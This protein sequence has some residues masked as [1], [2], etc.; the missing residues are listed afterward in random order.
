[1]SALTT[2]APALASVAAGK[3]DWFV[4]FPAHK[5]IGNV[6]YVGSRDLAGYLITTPGGTPSSTAASRGPSR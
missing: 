2:S 6:L 1:M 3:P 4:P 5:A